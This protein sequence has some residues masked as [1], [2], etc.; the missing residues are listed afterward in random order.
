MP[1]MMLIVATLNQPHSHFNLEIP[2]TQEALGDITGWFGEQLEALYNL[3]ASSEV[4]VE[5]FTTV[6]PRANGSKGIKYR[7][8]SQKR[9]TTSDLP[10]E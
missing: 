8:I 3:L 2:L 5:I 7:L 1:D 6:P 10:L 9:T 4:L